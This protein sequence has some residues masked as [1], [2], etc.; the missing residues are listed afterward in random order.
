MSSPYAWDL[1]NLYTTGE[2]TLTAAPE[3]TSHAAL[4][5]VVLL[6]F[7]SRSALVSQTRVSAERAGKR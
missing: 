3:P 2:V 4:L 1:S 5:L 6:I 7:A